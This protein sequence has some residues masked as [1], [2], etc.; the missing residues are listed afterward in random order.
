[1]VRRKIRYTCVH[2]DQDPAQVGNGLFYPTIF[3]QRASYLVTFRFHVKLWVRVGV[4]VG[5]RVK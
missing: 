1:M 5:V 3:Y 4:R 2:S